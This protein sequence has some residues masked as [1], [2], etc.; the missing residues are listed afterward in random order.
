M[1]KVVIKISNEMSKKLFL[2]SKGSLS[3]PLIK[4]TIKE[5]AP[6]E[7]LAHS[8]FLWESSLKSEASMESL[9]ATSISIFPHTQA[10]AMGL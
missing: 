6:F 7:E 5:W 1:Q 9:N 8:H 10:M 2:I 4:M 3:R